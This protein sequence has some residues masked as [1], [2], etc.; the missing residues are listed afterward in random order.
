MFNPM[1]TCHGGENIFKLNLRF[2]FPGPS[3]VV[4]MK[5]ALLGSKKNLKKKFSKRSKYKST[6]A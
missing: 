3:K 5:I 4:N 2:F 6:I 1:A